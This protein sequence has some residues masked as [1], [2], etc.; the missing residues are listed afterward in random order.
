MECGDIAVEIRRGKARWEGKLQNAK[1]RDQ[2]QADLSP[3]AVLGRP[4]RSAPF[5]DET[6]PRTG[7]PKTSPANP[8]PALPYTSWESRRSAMGLY[9]I[10]S[11]TS[12]GVLIFSMIG[13]EIQ[14]IVIR[15]PSAMS[16]SGLRAPV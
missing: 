11:A 8:P 14:L 10:L 15:Y 6:A 7:P 3:A 4:S 9:V 12:D 1:A 5:C 2:S 16:T 13:G